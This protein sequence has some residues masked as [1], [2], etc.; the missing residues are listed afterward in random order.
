MV[1]IVLFAILIVMFVFIYLI[2]H[3]VSKSVDRYLELPPLGKRYI[4]KK[5]TLSKE[6]VRVLSNNLDWLVTEIESNIPFFGKCFQETMDEMIFEAKLEV[7]N[8]I[9]H[10][11]SVLGLN[12]LHEQNKL[13]NTNEENIE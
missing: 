6:D 2:Q 3:R 13:L 9:Q 8:A 12:A 10:K 11:I 1:I 5:K 4:V 7:E